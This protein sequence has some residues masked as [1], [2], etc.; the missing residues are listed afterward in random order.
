MTRRIILTAALS[1]L[2]IPFLIF[3][4]TQTTNTV[5]V[6]FYGTIDT[7]LGTTLIINGRVVDIT[8]ATI[9]SPVL[10]A[11]M[12]V[13]IRAE[14]APNG[15]LIAQQVDYV[16]VGDIPGLVE[17]NGVVSE[18]NGATLRIGDQIIDIT[19]ARIVGTIAIGDSVQVFARAFNMNTWEAR[20]VMPAL[21]VLAPVTTPEVSSD[22]TAPV[23]APVSTPEVV[24]Q[25]NPPVT[26]P[27]I[28]DE[29]G[30]NSG[31]DS[32]DDQGDDHGGNSGHGGGDD[33]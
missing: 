29:H 16:T 10:A 4:Q 20:V 27:E 23:V 3:A 32:D 17:L 14:F 6:D 30:G 19:N 9:N 25:V 21:A 2:L 11:T 13:H 33:D 24:P 18:I 28:V 22:T 1:L 12:T 26:T 7:N 8:T 5:T 31:N 15:S